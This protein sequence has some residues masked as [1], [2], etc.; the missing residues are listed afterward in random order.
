MNEDKAVAVSGK[1][2]YMM[3]RADK[4]K[5]ALAREK[6]MKKLPYS[7]ILKIKHYRN[8]T[9]EQ[10]LQLIDKLELLAVLLLESY[11]FTQ[12]NST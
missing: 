2:R 6:L 1:I 10:Y 4:S 5:M 3:E 8:F 9:M 7:A 12:N 11:I